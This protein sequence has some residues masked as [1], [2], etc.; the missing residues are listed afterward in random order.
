[1]FT[2]LVD[3]TLPNMFERREF[4]YGSEAQGAGGYSLPFLA[5]RCSAA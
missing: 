4:V 2:P 3:P 1:V 5:V